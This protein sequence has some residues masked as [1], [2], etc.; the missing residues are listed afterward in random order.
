MYQKSGFEAA[1]QAALHA[2]LAYLL[3]LS[4]QRYVSPY[5]IS[6]LYA[7]T[8]D[9]QQSLAWLQTAYKQRDVALPSLRQS[10]D[11]AFASVKNEPEFQ[12][13]LSNIHYPAQH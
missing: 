10:Q 11:D 7:R 8:G 3:S 12:Q 2:R 13:I 4:K 1:K 9:K 5:E 6:A